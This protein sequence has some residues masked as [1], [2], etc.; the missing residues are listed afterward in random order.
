MKRSDLIGQIATEFDL[1]RA[2]AERIVGTV[3]GSIVDAAGRGDRVSLA[4]FGNF[5]VRK[6]A[7]RTVRVPRTGGTV[8][9]NAQR[10]LA[11]RPAKAVRD[12]LNRN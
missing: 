1:S 5:E 12:V 2:T 10:L 11:F 3:F 7:A 9:V 4:G 6:R 8:S